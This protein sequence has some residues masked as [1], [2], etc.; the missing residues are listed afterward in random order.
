M[1]LRASSWICFPVIAIGTMASIGMAADSPIVA[2]KTRL[3]AS[4]PATWKPV[5]YQAVS[6]IGGVTLND[7]GLFK[8]VMENNIGYLLNSFSVDH[9]LVPFR[10]RAGKPNP[11]Q[12]K[13]QVNIWDTNL[14][15]SNAGRFL[16]G[17]GNTLRWIDNAELRNRLDALIDG[18]E[19]CREPL[20][21][22]RK[23]RQL[24]SSEQVPLR[25]ECHA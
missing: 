5:A 22:G 11:P 18:I 3:T 17:G 20:A 15:G 23:A 2:Y 25:P 4:D 7:A 6:P 13:P 1:L 24:V 16:M 21:I 10:D 8:P 9:M 14:R 12:E 19:A